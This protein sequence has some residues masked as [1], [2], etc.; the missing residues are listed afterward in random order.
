MYKPNSREAALLLLRAIEERG[1]RR[2]KEIT[3]ARVSRVTLRRLWNREILNDPWLTEIN[4]WL[5]S[6]GWTLVYA[7]TIGVVKTSV[8]ENWPRIASKH[9]GSVVE[10]V[11]QGGYDFSQLEH[12]M[13]SKSVPPTDQAAN[14]DDE[15]GN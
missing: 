1:E 8:V 5:L 6:A 10:G 13:H 15:K 14:G 2:D 3:R 11:R 12:L 9:L 7:G 4:D